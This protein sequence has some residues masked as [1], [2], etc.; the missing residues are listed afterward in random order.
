MESMRVIRKSCNL[1]A[2]PI[3]IIKVE[4]L[5]KMTKIRLCSNVTDLNEVTIK[6][7]GLISYQQPVFDH[8]KGAK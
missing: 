2:S 3:T 6:D 5:D 7:A 8:M 1:Y 4:K